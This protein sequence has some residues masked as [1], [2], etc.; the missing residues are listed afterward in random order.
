MPEYSIYDIGYDKTL[1]R[2]GDISADLPSSPM[3]DVGAFGSYAGGIVQDP[4]SSATAPNV[5]TSG[6]LSQV[7]F[8]GKQTFSDSTSGF[9]MG[10]DSDGIFKFIIGS[11]SSYMDWSVTSVGVL[12]ISGSLNAT[13]G[14]IGGFTIGSDYI[15]DVGN[16]FGLASTI[17]GGDD[18]RFWA[19]SA[20]SARATAPVRIY[21]SGTA[22]FSSATVN[23]SPVTNNDTFGSGAD[24]A[25]VLDG[26]N[27]Y[28]TYFSKSGSDYTQLMDVYATN[29][30]L[31]GTATL[32]TAGYRLFAN[33]T[34]TVG[35]SCVIKRNGNN[36][37]NGTNATALHVPGTGGA[38][39]AALASGSVFGSLAGASG[40]DGGD[41]GQTGGPR[42]GIAGGGGT[43]GTAANN[44]YFLGTYSGNGISGGAGGQGGG[45]GGGNTPGAAGS[46]GTGG[47]VSASTVRPH[48]AVY[49]VQMLDI[50][51]G[52]SVAFLRYAPGVGGS[53]GGGGGSSGWPDS[54]AGDGGSGGGGGGSGSNGGTIVIAARILINNGTVQAVGG[55]GGNGGNGFAGSTLSGIGGGGGGGGNGGRGGAGG[56]IACIYSSLSGSGTFSVAGGAGGSAGTGGA[57]GGGGTPGTAGSNGTNGTTG[58]SGIIIQMAV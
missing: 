21:E 30:T 25:F 42:A 44:S 45:S 55:N 53:G 38:G 34:L 26:T 8:S 12:T 35:A 41:G 47:T 49:A 37:S 58:P 10:V 24:G 27:T 2:G 1:S 13:S 33:G 11:G 29:I 5:L 18:V 48:S 56:V 6:D 46:G 4:T 36:A 14:T 28:A 16:S 52:A 50:V 51:A 3:P 43:N 22:V 7:I 9:R 54:P 57:G 39:G 23:G 31:S 20:F 15:R 32:N 40:G 17:T 19:G